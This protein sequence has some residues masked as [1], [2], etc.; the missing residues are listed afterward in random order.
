MIVASYWYAKTEQ[1][2]RIGDK[3][4]CYCNSPRC[5]GYSYMCVSEYGCFSQVT[6]DSSY[7][8][9]CVE[10][11]VMIE[12]CL[13]AEE[14]TFKRLNK[15]LIKADQTLDIGVQLL[16][17]CYDDMCNYANY[18]QEEQRSTI[19]GNRDH[20]P[21]NEITSFSSKA[22][23]FRAA[24]IAV[25][26]AGVCILILLAMLASK[27]LSNDNNKQTF[28]PL[29]NH[30][31]PTTS[32]S[33]PQKRTH[34]SR[35]LHGQPYR[36]QK[37]AALYFNSRVPSSS[38]NETTYLESEAVRSSLPGDIVQENLRFARNFGESEGLLSSSVG[39]AQ[40]PF[41]SPK[42]SNEPQFLSHQH[43]TVSQFYPPA[44]TEKLQIV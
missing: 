13:Q 31:P 7:S 38:M 44:R 23:W 11:L 14:E 17:C 36:S 4:H 9:G 5:V 10:D 39:A 24:V 19:N 22:V 1:R 15:S 34:H 28:S 21:N 37:R 25:P 18:E 41:G 20:Y 6:T 2:I 40:G 12:R 32:N 26:I 43:I 16:S 29:N 35:P 33:Y 42:C 27:L 8:R 30:R 3:V